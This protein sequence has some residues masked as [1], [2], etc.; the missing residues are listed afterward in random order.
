MP[1]RARPPPSPE[2]RPPRD[3]RQ[4]RGG[5]R[6]RGRGPP[7]DQGDRSPR[8]NP[9]DGRDSGRP[10]IRLRFDPAQIKLTDAQSAQIRDLDERLRAIGE[11]K[12]PSRDD[13][14]RRL[15][16]IE[17]E[18]QRLYAQRDVLNRR[19]EE[20]QSEL[21]GH[22]HGREDAGSRGVFAAYQD[23]VKERDRLESDLQEIQTRRG[24]KVALLKDTRARVAFKNQ[25]EARGR[26][27]QIDEEIETRTL[28]NAQL[29]K[30]LSDKEKVQAAFKSLEAVTKLD[31]DVEALRAQERD[32][33]AELET[34]RERVSQAREARNAV[35]GSKDQQQSVHQKIRGEIREIR[36]QINTVL[37]QIRQ[38]NQERQT[39]H[40][41]FRAAWAEFRAKLQQRSEIGYEKKVIYSEAERVMIQIEEGRKRVGAIKDF[42]NPHEA[43]ISAGVALLA[44][45]EDFADRQS[46]K[47]APVVQPRK[48]AK[49]DE[50]AFIAELRKPSKKDRMA[51]KKV[52]Q[53]AKPTTLAH[54]VAALVQFDKVGLTAPIS[55]DQIPGIVEALRAKVKVWKESFTAARVNFKV[56]DDGKV[57]VTITVG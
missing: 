22:L 18:I 40:T 57:A 47:E 56:Q 28:T 20:K 19:Q 1:A 6:G 8:R 5:F 46:E 12:E 4:S 9:R 33:R 36:G 41:D 51:A 42:V 14:D 55:V 13:H 54:D 16:E 27:D 21:E 24:Q 3:D 53:P 23:A 38:K 7:P 39:A 49:S 37:D 34:S 2:E 32:K 45:L 31:A 48:G 29:K 26:L 52:Q 35:Q 11:A 25:E 17:N 15:Q 10:P 44:Y 50:L 30:L 43:E